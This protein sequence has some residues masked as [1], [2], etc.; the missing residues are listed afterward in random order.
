VDKVDIGMDENEYRKI[1]K[2]TLSRIESA[3][4]AVDPDIAECDQQFGALT[5]RL[6][7]GSRCILSA[8]PSVRQ[9]W[10][11]V[12]SKGVAFHFNYVSAD[13]QWVDDRGQGLEL[14]SYLKAYLLEACR[15][16]LAIADPAIGG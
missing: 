2:E 14:I 4:E 13:R 9:L 16:E 11:A 12:A 8:Q 10:L 15:L 6:V 7:D 3:F 1:V 5:I